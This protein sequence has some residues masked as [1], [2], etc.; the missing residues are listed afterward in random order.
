MQKVSDKAQRPSVVKS[1][2]ITVIRQSPHWIKCTIEP[3]PKTIKRKNHHTCKHVLVPCH[4][5]SCRALYSFLIHGE[6][7]GVDAA[8]RLCRSDQK[9]KSAPSSGQFVQHSL[10][11]SWNQEEKAICS[12][13][14]RRITNYTSVNSES[15]WRLESSTKRYSPKG[16][17]H[18]VDPTWVTH[19]LKLVLSNWDVEC[20]GR[21][22]KHQ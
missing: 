22:K 21:A 3:S 8:F 11:R 14:R 13:L 5:M 19:L 15:G 17:C 18:L 10:D 1:N 4:E 6:N 7:M 2:P 20:T 9:V 16:P 12:T